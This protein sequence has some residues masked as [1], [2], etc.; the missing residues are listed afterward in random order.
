MPC[1]ECLFFINQKLKYIVNATLTS[2]LT[3]GPYIQL[4]CDAAAN[5]QYSSI[6]EALLQSKNVNDLPPLIQLD[7]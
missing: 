2:Q 4:I 3:S 5:L 1:Q 6:V 7:N